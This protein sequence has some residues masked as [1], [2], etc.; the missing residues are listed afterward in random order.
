MASARSGT[1]AL[2][3]K[4]PLALGMRP[5]IQGMVPLRARVTVEPPMLAATCRPSTCRG[6]QGPRYYL[7][8]DF[9]G[10]LPR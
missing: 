6:D 7:G 9:V 3:M 1:A 2:P 8:A 4:N 5:L 10:Y